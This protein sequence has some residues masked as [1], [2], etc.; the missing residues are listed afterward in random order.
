MS[1]C[2]F[3]AYEADHD[4]ILELGYS[5]YNTRTHEFVSAHYL[6]SENAQYGNG[7]YVPDHRHLFQFGQTIT[8]PLATVFMDLE[9]Q[10]R[11]AYCV[12]GHDLH[13]EKS[14]LA[15]YCGSGVKQLWFVDTQSLFKQLYPGRGLSL[16]RVLD[17]LGIHHAH[18]HNAG[19][20]ARY[21]LMAF[22]S[23][24]HAAEQD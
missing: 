8:A 14:I 19:N 16:A 9:E 23:L 1:S 20:D 24:L 15:K 11:T 21:V 4:K 5:S 2:S 3:L 6:I 22:V 10:L 18:L 12:V 7:R 13:A 17:T